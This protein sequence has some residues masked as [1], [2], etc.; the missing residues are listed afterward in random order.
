MKRKFEL[1][2]NPLWFSGF[3]CFAIKTNTSHDGLS[4]EAIDFLKF[5]ET[6]VDEQSPTPLG[7]GAKSVDVA[8]MQFPEKFGDLN[9]K[10]DP[11]PFG[12]DLKKDNPIWGNR[13]CYASGKELEILFSQKTKGSNMARVFFLI[14]NHSNFGG[15]IHLTHKK[16][17]KSACS[18]IGMSYMAFVTNVKRLVSCDLLTLNSGGWYNCYSREDM[19]L[20]LQ[21]SNVR[22]FLDHRAL[23]SQSQMTSY[24]YGAT[25]HAQHEVYKNYRSITPNSFFIPTEIGEGDFQCQDIGVCY[26][27]RSVGS[28]VKDYQPVSSE[29]LEGF[30]FRSSSSYR[31]NK[32]RIEKCGYGKFK[33]TEMQLRFEDKFLRD[34]K[35]AKLK[36]NLHQE[37]L[38][39]PMPIKVKSGSLGHY[40]IFEMPSHFVPTL[41]VRSNNFSTE[42]K[43]R[44]S[45]KG[46]YTIQER[47]AIQHNMNVSV[48]KKKIKSLG[49]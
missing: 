8:S 15:Q 25:I 33:R 40:I 4:D 17:I 34:E 9:F 19:G 23:L 22:V 36:Y 48:V 12:L 30:G 18:L 7:G 46:V 11:T 14:K 2:G 3:F 26:H 37:N 32:T 20:E 45:V 5:I 28:Y 47:Y 43:K 1:P 29:Y 44:M 21:G 41:L 35:V 38:D 27:N 42:V 31:R 13:I 39:T 49:K 10:P 16:K 24:L 6:P